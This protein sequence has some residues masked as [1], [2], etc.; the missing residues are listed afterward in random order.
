MAL[1]L[2]DGKIHDM[3]SLDVNK[4]TIKYQMKP[5]QIAVMYRISL[6]AGTEK[7]FNETI[8]Y[9]ALEEIRKIH[10]N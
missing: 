4:D 8:G 9:E 1:L 2:C 6:T 10:A 5:G 7:L 3:F